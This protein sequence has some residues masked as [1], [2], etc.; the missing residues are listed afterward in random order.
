MHAIRQPRVFSR[1]ALML[2]VLLLAGICARGSAAKAD[3]DDDAERVPSGAADIY[4]P[5]DR[6]FTHQPPL[7]GGSRRLVPGTSLPAETGFVALQD[8]KDRL[9]FTDPFFRDTVLAVYLR[10]HALDR[11]NSDQTQSQAWA[12]G[13]L[14]AVRTGFLRDWLQFEVAAATSQPLYAP[15]GDGGTLLLTDNQAEISS[16]AIAN[17]R[18]RFGGQEIVLGRQLVKTPYINPQDNRMLPNTVEGAVLTAT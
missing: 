11:N 8:L 3:Q 1:S 5:I 10:T 17:A 9:R 14:I 18:M 7:P 12:G 4:S 16:P 13:S 6:T 15:E 2:G